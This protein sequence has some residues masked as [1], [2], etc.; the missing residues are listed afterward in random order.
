MWDTLCVP[1]AHGRHGRDY[2]HAVHMPEVKAKVTP[3]G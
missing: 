3:C 2:A 1:I